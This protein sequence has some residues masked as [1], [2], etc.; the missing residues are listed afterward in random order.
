MFNFEKVDVK[1]LKL[2]ANESF[3]GKL[4]QISDKPWNDKKSG[5]LKTIK[6]FHFDTFNEKGEPSGQIIYF[7]DGG[8]TN[9]ISMAGI[10]ELDTVKVVKKAKEDIGQGRSVN[11]Y[12][13]F[14]AKA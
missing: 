1:I 3:I 7:G 6:Q 12:E 8:F 5:E 14:K 9:A 10:K 2:K 4:M 11:T 13:I